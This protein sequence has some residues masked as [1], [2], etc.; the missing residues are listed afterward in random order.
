MVILVVLKYFYERIERELKRHV[1]KL[2]VFLFCFFVVA[3]AASATTGSETPAEEPDLKIAIISDVHISGRQ[4]QQERFK[5]ALADS[6]GTAPGYDVLAIVGD[7]TT[8]GFDYEYDEFNNILKQHSILGAEKFISI[9]NHEFF[10][11]RFGPNKELT[12]E[13]MKN[14]F[15]EKVRQ[16]DTLGGINNVYY[17]KWISGYHFIT[18]GSE[19]TNPSNWDIPNIRSAQYDWLEETIAVDA[20]PNRPIFVFLHQPIDNT[21]YCSEEWGARLPDDRLKKILQQY[22]Q[23]ILFSGHT[24]CLLQHPRTVFQDRFTMV[25]TGA[26][27][28]SYFEGGIGQPD[29]SQGLL[30]DVYK[31]RVE[32]KAREFSTGS[33]IQTFEV[34]V[35]FEQTI[36]DTAPPFFKVGSKV[37]IEHG[38]NEEYLTW[39][40]AA[41]NTL[42]DKYVIRQIV[43]QESKLLKTVYVDFWNKGATSA[44]VKTTLAGLSSGKKYHLEILAIDAWGNQSELP[45]K[46]DI[47]VPYFEGWE[48]LIGHWYYFDPD[49]G[50]YKTGFIQLGEK[51]YYLD[52]DGKMLTGWFKVQDKW[53][54]AANDGSLQTGWLKQGEKYYYMNPDGAM[55][56]GWLKLKNK[57]YYLDNTGVLKTGWMKVD[58]N[59]HYFARDGAMVTGG[60]FNDRSK[61]YFF[62]PDGI[63]MTGW[64]KDKG[65]WYLLDQTGEMRTGW[66]MDKEKWYYLSPEGKMQTGWLKSGNKWYYLAANGE[67]HVG[68]GNIGYRWYFFDKSGSMQ[69]GWIKD[70]EKWYYLTSSGAMKTG[71]H[72]EGN[73]WYYLDTSGTMQTGW[74]KI[75]I[76]KYFLDANGVWRP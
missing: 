63:M 27:D 24:H 6:K 12:D 50:Y 9:G 2:L 46:T 61:W 7:L 14:R 1:S 10:E 26:V 67:M 44:P 31:N 37:N 8:R 53:Y 54:F 36:E 4:H 16:I 34:K 48:E 71:W 72:K 29:F 22:P 41:D 33:W 56:T 45:L 66:A 62:S 20:D 19:S 25:N 39:E 32:I 15:I 65:S 42:V 13:D 58:Q 23:A 68:W 52:Y 28:N 49:T 30:V 75:G 11:R 51:R 35:P 43:D 55:Q 69:T 18:L 3:S 40:P 47:T 73:K 57:Q 59:W 17:D 5:K 21:V 76:N 64:I 74:I 70:G 60:W 38:P